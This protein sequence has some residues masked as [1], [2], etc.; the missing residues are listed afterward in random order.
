MSLAFRIWLV[1]LAL[2]I[3][4]WFSLTA[5]ARAQDQAL[6][7]LHDYGFVQDAETREALERAA[8]ALMSAE[9]ASRQP[10]AR[11]VD[12]AFSVLRQTASAD[13]YRGQLETAA[14]AR[15][16][17]HLARPRPDLEAL[18]QAHGMLVLAGAEDA[19]EQLARIAA[20]AGNRAAAA[21][22]L[23]ASAA[24]LRDAAGAPAGD[25]EL[26]RL[27]EVRDALLAPQDGAGP[28]TWAVR[29]EPTVATALEDAAQSALIH[30]E[31]LVAAAR[32]DGAARAASADLRP[33]LIAAWHALQAMGIADRCDGLTLSAYA[34][35]TRRRGLGISE[36][37]VVLALALSLIGGAAA[38]ARRLWRG[39]SP[40]DPGAETLENE[41][42][43]D[44][45]T[46]AET[47]EAAR[48]R[49]GND[50][51]VG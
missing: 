45:D 28:V 29:E 30:F 33:R 32:A 42:P 18:R 13:R 12:V 49:P 2:V 20:L 26:V 44:F 31:A 23:A 6:A 21:S 36:W 46:D 37:L 40:I 51:T 47:L 38:A 17:A 10:D 24:R 48:S 4:G 34:D 43:I 9:L 19:R 35:A 39:P 14:R 11:M 16:N 50:T 8:A 7:S 25:V 41:S 22:D 27:V 1:V 3:A 15:L 5:S